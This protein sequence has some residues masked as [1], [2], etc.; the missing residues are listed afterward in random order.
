M[1]FQ[2]PY[3]KGAPGTTGKMV[4]ASNFSRINSLVAGFGRGGGGEG[5]ARGFQVEKQKC[6]LPRMRTFP[7][8][9]LHT[10]GWIWKRK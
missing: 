3:G 7:R 4:A 1:A 10:G 5:R 2:S 6:K 9:R 8:L